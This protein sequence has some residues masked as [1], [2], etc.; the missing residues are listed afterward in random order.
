MSSRSSCSDICSCS[1][2]SA[3]G[4]R[5]PARPAC[6]QHGG[7]RDE[8]GE[9]L[10][11]DAGLR[12]AGGGGRPALGSSSSAGG[13]DGARRAGGTAANGSP[14]CSSRCGRGGRAPRATSSGGPRTRACSP[15]PSTQAMSSR[16]MAYEV[17]KTRP[18]VL[19]G[20][21][22]AVGAEVALDVPGDAVGHPDLG[23]AHRVAELPRHAVGVLARV[24]VVG[25]LEVVLGLGRVGDLAADARE[26]EDADRLALVRVADEVELAALE[27]QLVGVDP[28]HRGLAA[29]ASCSTRT[30]SACAG[31]SRCRSSPARADS[32]CPP[33]DAVM[34]RP[35]ERWA[36][37]SSGLGRP[38]VICCS[39]R[40]SGSA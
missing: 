2:T 37:E 3:T 40:R 29:S 35:I 22:L 32:S 18:A 23:G 36:G 26:A 4:R 19:G 5:S 1:Q 13:R 14:R 16:G 33:A 30:R 34:P 25:A 17:R 27:Q 24:E 15:K 6:D 7:E 21:H 12:A 10:R 28:A 8:A 20:A 39:A 9:A 11:A 31:R 38:Q